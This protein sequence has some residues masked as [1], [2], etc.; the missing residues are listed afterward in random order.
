M[1]DRND[2]LDLLSKDFEFVKDVVQAIDGKVDVLN[3]TMERNTISLEKHER[4]TELAELRIDT[5]ETVTF[6]LDKRIQPLEVASTKK[7]GAW[8]A[9]LKISKVLTIMGG[10]FSFAYTLLHL[11]NI[12]P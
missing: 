6:G 10:F 9:F 5:I 11:F 12:L 1:A 4:R 8:E 2:R 3:K 7:Q